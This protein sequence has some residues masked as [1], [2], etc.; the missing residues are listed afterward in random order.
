M[1]NF[2]HEQNFYILFYLLLTLILFE[3]RFWLFRGK[4]F[5]IHEF[6]NS[7]SLCGLLCFRLQRILNCMTLLHLCLPQSYE[8]KSPPWTI[9]GFRIPGIFSVENRD[10]LEDFM[11]QTSD[12][13]QLCI[14]S[15]YVLFS[16]DDICLKFET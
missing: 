2:A 7:W 10:R 3:N 5:F 12:N 15:Q 11:F 16:A 1:S 9:W 4:T 13:S 6:T 14:D 8:I